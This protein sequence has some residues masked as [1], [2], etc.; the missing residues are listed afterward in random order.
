MGLK[1]EKD[2]THLADC[3][4][5]HRLLAYISK[6]VCIKYNVSPKAY[7]SLTVVA[8]CRFKITFMLAETLLTA[9]LQYDIFE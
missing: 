7:D 4:N 3:E 5:A 2:G 9:Y 6:S 8:V 1:V